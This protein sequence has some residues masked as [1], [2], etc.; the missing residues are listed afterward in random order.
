MREYRPR[1]S[2]VIE[3]RL[4]S[5]AA[6]PRRV[7]D[8]ETWTKASTLPPGTTSDEERLNGRRAV[9]RHSMLSGHG[10]TGKRCASAAHGADRTE[11]DELL[12]ALGLGGE[13]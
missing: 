9:A 12:S 7:A 4:A 8:S 3:R 1:A 11:R 13:R 5:A 6:G 10:C 2:D